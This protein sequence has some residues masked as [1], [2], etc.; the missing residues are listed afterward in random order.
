MS[1]ASEA[2]K[3]GVVVSIPVTQT[4]LTSFVSSPF[5]SK[6]NAFRISTLPK[7]LSKHFVMQAINRLRSA[8]EKTTNPGWSP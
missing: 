2:M 3:H 8:T 7:P 1:V 5:T 4:H 6:S